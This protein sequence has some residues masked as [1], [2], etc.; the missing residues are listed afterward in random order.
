MDTSPYFCANL[1]TLD[2]E[3]HERFDGWAKSQQKKHL[4]TQ[5]GDDFLLFG[6]R[7]DKTRKSHMV[8]LRTT[9]SN[10]GVKLQLPPGFLKLISKEE[11]DAAGSTAAI[12]TPGA[13]SAQS[14]DVSPTPTCLSSGFDQRASAMLA[15]I[16]AH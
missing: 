4:L 2:P 6:E 12:Q 8:A 15:A 9:L 16:R 7:G 11:L 10:W 14:C 1:G 5:A 3:T 13:P